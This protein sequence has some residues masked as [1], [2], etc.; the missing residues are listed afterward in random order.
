LKITV[1]PDNIMVFDFVVP[2]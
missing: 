1:F 2:P